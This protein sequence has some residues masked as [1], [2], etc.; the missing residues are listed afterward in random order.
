MQR[1]TLRYEFYDPAARALVI[2]QLIRKLNFHMQF[3]T[4]WLSSSNCEIAKAKRGETSS[5]T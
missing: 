1:Q 5:Q 2:T 4:R 3:A